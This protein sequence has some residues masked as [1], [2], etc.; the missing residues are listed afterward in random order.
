MLLHQSEAETTM[1]SATP[2]LAYLGSV[3]ILYGLLA[4]GYQIAYDEATRLT[5][6]ME[7][8]FTLLQIVYAAA[9]WWRLRT[10]RRSDQPQ[11]RI[12]A[13]LTILTLACGLLA[14]FGLGLD[15][16]LF[17][18]TTAIYLMA[19]PPRPALIFTVL[20]V[21]F[22]GLIM[23]VIDNWNWPDAF[24]NWL[25]QMF[26][27]VLAT[28]FL[29]VL[30]VVTVQKAQTERL[31]KQLE[32]SK[33]ELEHA[34]QQLQCY[35]QEVEELAVVRERT[36]LAREIH[37]ILG[38]YL[39]LLNIQ[40]G[41]M[42]KVYAAG[43]ADLCTD[44][45]EARQLAGLATQE[46]RDAVVALRPAN[47]SLLDALAQLGSEFTG[48]NK[49]TCLT[50]DLETQLPEIPQE[51]QVAFY[52]AAQEALTNVCK[53]ARATKTLLRLRYEDHVL[54]LTV[55]DNGVG[56]SAAA[57]QR[58]GGFGLTGLRERFE[59]LGGQV[60]SGSDE[61]RGYRVNAWLRLVP[62][63]PATEV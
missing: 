28:I 57:E 51:V 52:R 7:S 42:C 39:S 30:R 12:T 49:N 58:S 60:T 17:L 32:Q 37:D 15:W 9:L 16:L 43:P 46:V 22:L 1:P 20:L 55:L 4:A 35:A 11:H 21:A 50:L 38:H 59:M 6:A 10:G 27:F 31:L 56:Y 34:H 3:I 33:T 54:N 41:T 45:R 36:R 5:P 14:L 8:I 23:V 29:L 47:I 26:S 44:I 2:R 61:Q 24:V 53:H 48:S 19:Y 62:G 25:Y 63:A 40:L 18:A 13:L